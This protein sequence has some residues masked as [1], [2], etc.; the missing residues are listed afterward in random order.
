MQIVIELRINGKILQ[1]VDMSQYPPYE[2]CN[3][4]YAHILPGFENFGPGR[5]DFG[6]WISVKD[7]LPGQ[8]TRVLVYCKSEEGDES[9]CNSSFFCHTAYLCRFSD[10]FIES[11]PNCGCTGLSGEVTHWMALPEAPK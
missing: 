4:D 2:T 11:L 7:R 3:L 1:Y 8:G 6:K 10:Y 5:D 9:D